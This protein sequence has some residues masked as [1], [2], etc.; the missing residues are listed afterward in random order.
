M[1]PNM[2]MGPG[3]PR[4]MEPNMMM[5]PGGPRHMMMDGPRGP[6][7]DP[8]MMGPGGPG[9]MMGGPMRPGVPGPKGDKRIY[10]IFGV[11][12]IIPIK[13]WPSKR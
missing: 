9:N 2:M 7:M 10:S 5:G 1:E 11:N 12:L 13:F 6:M 8:N 4:H 3:G